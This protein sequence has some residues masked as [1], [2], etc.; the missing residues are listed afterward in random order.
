MQKIIKLKPTDQMTKWIKSKGAALGINPLAT[1]TLS[2][3]KRLRKIDEM[4][5]FQSALSIEG[6]D[7]ISLIEQYVKE[8]LKRRGY[9]KI[10]PKR[11]EHTA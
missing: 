1:I 7:S 2:L 9:F 4:P 10:K 11:N 8:T 5:E 6:G 3:L